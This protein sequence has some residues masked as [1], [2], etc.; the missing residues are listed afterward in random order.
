MSAIREGVL[1]SVPE[2]VLSLMTWRELESA[3][4]GRPEI[5][6]Q[7]L[8]GMTAMNLPASS[9]L[10]DWF[11]SV[12]F[13]F[14]NEDRAAFLAFACGRSRLPSRG[15]ATVL[16]VNT[17]STRG[18]VHCPTSHTCMLTIELPAYSSEEVRAEQ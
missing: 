10:A 6:I 14:T 16:T 7:V 4:C 18:D 13:S 3:V 1:S 11:W 15:S 17:D 12:L 2:L 5:D 9:P 8:K